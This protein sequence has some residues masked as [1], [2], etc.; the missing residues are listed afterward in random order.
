MYGNNIRKIP[1]GLLRSSSLRV[2]E[3][4]SNDI[5]SLP[6][7]L[8]AMKSIKYIDLSYNPLPRAEVRRID[9]SYRGITINTQTRSK[10][11]YS[12]REALMEP[13][14]A[15]GIYDSYNDE[16]IDRLPYDSLKWTKYLVLEDN[17]FTRIPDG[18]LEL[19]Q[20]KTLNLSGNQIRE[21][22][23][24]ITKMKSL[25]TLILSG[26]PIRSI[27]PELRQLSELTDLYLYDC[28][29][30]DVPEWVKDMPN[31]AELSLSKNNLSTEKKELIRSWFMGRDIR[32]FL[33]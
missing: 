20:L 5:K 9:T 6:K 19:R 32:L 18:I 25:K 21:I 30:T 22:P 27:P 17:G 26:N 23:A 2:L 16:L 4:G 1:V 29:L 10:D 12:V 24:G 3:I 7:D 31:L 28:D 15:E 13:K 11:F 14:D 33:D 8:S